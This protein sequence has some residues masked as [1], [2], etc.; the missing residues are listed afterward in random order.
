MSDVQ[1]T[2]VTP[3]RHNNDD[4]VPSNT[5]TTMYSIR[6][7]MMHQVTQYEIIIRKAPSN[8][9]IPNLVPH[10][11]RDRNEMKPYKTKNLGMNDDG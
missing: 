9:I 3:E 5:I 6:V 2:H 11:R 7:I 10:V 4:K 1:G 8:T